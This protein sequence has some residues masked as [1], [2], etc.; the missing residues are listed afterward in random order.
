MAGRRVRPTAWRHARRL[1]SAGR[2][3][4]LLHH[5]RDVVRRE[6]IRL[7]G[8]RALSK[9]MLEGS[10]ILL[11]ERRHVHGWHTGLGQIRGHG[12]TQGMPLRGTYGL[13][14]LGRRRSRL[15]QQPQA[16]QRNDHQPA[17]SKPSALSAHHGILLVRAVRHCGRKEELFDLQRIASANLPDRHTCE[18]FCSDQEH[19]TDHPSS[20]VHRSSS[21]D[22][23]RAGCAGCQCIAPPPGF[24]LSTRNKDANASW[25]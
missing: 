5:G 14:G 11:R 20:P 22:F 17:A 3:A 15:V 7:R 24:G 21:L 13:R 6:R 12:L 25:Q 16:K 1:T 23:P 18:R 8:G 2:R 10:K 19:E 4:Y 9:G